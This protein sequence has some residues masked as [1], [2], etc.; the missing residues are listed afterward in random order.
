M[1]SRQ[2]AALACAAA[3]LG[4]LAGCGGD[5]DK[6]SSSAKAKKPAGP[7]QVRVAVVMASLDNDFYVAQKEGAEAAAAK[8]SAAEVTVSAGRQRASTEEVISLIDDAL[9]KGVDAIAVNGSDNEPLMPALKRVIAA[10]VPL[11][12]FDAPAP[13]LKGQYATYVGTDNEKGGEA[14]GEWLKGALR[15]GGKVG[16]VL[17]VAGHPVTTARLNGFKAG[18]GDAFKVV[19]TA[20]AECDREKGRKVMEDMIS[21]HKDLDAVFSTSDSQTL[22]AVAALQAAGEDP[23]MVSFDAQPEVVKD[24]VAGKVVD[25]STGWSAKEIGGDAVTAAIAAA[26][27][28][29][30][31]PERIVPVTVVDKDNA[32]SWEG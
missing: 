16:V 27:G 17:C 4:G 30:V 1:G 29:K 3:A 9:A 25:A 7:K 20:D 8:D 21:A 28:E 11:V 15:D 19:A 14:A 10:K 18:A 23:E 13:E 26:R 5:D 12:L 22:G 6:A 32:S 31:E 2:L 24:I